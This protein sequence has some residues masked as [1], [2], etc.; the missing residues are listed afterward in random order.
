[1]R[2]RCQLSDPS[3]PHDVDTEHAY[4]RVTGWAQ[5]RGAEG[6]IHALALRQSLHEYACYACIERA[7]KNIPIAQTTLFE[8]G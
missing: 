2:V 5:Q 6:G 4:R 8:G 1:M 3:S 7:K